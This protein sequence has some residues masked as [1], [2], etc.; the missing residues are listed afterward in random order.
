MRPDRSSSADALSPPEESP[1]HPRSRSWWGRSLRVKIIVWFFV[2]T[3]LLLTAVA[4]INFFAYQDVTADLVIERDQDVT[5]LSA[6][7]LSTSLGEFT[8]ALEEVG[9]SMDPSQPPGPSRFPVLQ[10]LGT[11]AVFDGGVVVLDTFGVPVAALPEG[12][13]SLYDDWSSV[14]IFRELFRSTRPV[15]SNILRGRTEDDEVVAMGVPIVGARGEF[16]GATVGMFNVGAT[17]VS[18]FYGRIVRLRL[19]QDGAVYLVDETGKV[20]YHSNIALAGSDFSDEVAVQQVFTS[21]VGALRTTGATGQDVVAAYSPVPGTPW[22]LV[23]ETSWSSLTSGSRDYQRLLLV[24]LAFGILAPIVIV[25]VGIRRLMRPVDELIGAA[26]AVGAGNFSRRIESPS[27]DEIG[28]LAEQFNTMAAALN[29]SYADLEQRVAARTQELHESDERLRTLVTGAPVVLFA[30]DREGIFTL[31]EGRGLD[32]LELRP[33]EL[34]GQSVFDVYRDIPEIGASINRALAGEEVTSTVEVGGL[35]FESRYRP[36]SGENGAV[37]GVIG[38]ATD[39]SE[40][41]QAEEALRKSEEEFRSLFED[42][43]DA[44]YISAPDGKVL[45]VNQAALDLFGFTRDEAIGSDVGDR[46]VEPSYR[47]RF[48]QEIA[49]TGGIRNFEVKLRK[50]NGSEMHCLLTATRRRAKNGGI[51]G[52]SQGV[53]RDITELKRAEAALRENETMLRQSEKMAVL[54]TLT[55]GVAHEL[56]NPAAAVSSGATHLEGAIVQFGQ[57]QSQLSQLDLTAAQQSELQRLTQ[58]VLQRAARPPELNALARS[59]REGELQAWLEER[60]MPDA[61]R[62]APTLVNLNYDSAG[63]TALAESFAPDQLPAIIGGLD[64]TY[65]VHNVLTE[66]GQSAG[67][68]SEIVKALKSY[69]YLDQAPVQAVDLHEGLDNTLLVLGH[70]LKSGISVRREYAPDLPNIQANGSELNQVWT[71]IIDNAADALQGQG[72]ITIRTRHEGEWVVIEIEDDGPGIPAEIQPRVFEP[73]YTT[74][75]PGQGTG[76]GLD[77]SYNIVAHNHRGDINVFSEPGKTCFR[78]RLPVNAPPTKAR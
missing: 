56:N 77:I 51:S 47:E 45:D 40:R 65:T 2:P 36:I 25:G 66:I 53:I 46:F 16:L 64:A 26:Q 73:F 42:S 22:S 71:N 70:K 19:N 12:S 57:A 8:E 28:V 14:P 61:W 37:V 15:F 27:S 4:V 21:R 38:V 41:R 76:L 63:L 67:R 55:A 52:G 6:S 18:A 29:E 31:S 30:I 75:P 24:L 68:I 54:G 13:D 5:R 34:V 33:G 59:D 72:E 78:V 69:S 43:R 7:Q 11:L 35:T 23:S 48:R 74:K 49:S 44:I 9:R 32:A 60:G 58:E 20:I 10:T 1:E 50:K 3:A 39:V 62:L 17:A